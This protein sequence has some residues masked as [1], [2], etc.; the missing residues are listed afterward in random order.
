[1]DKFP[2]MEGNLPAI[3][4]TKKRGGKKKREKRG[5]KVGKIREKFGKKTGKKR[6]KLGNDTGIKMCYN[7]SMRNWDFEKRPQFFI[8]IIVRSVLK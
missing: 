3:G 4:M 1:M 5:K 2:S 6:E 7:S 8:Y